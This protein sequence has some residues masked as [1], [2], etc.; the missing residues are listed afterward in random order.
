MSVEADIAWAAGIFEGEGTVYV[1][2]RKHKVRDYLTAMAA[3]DM[4]DG[5]IVNRFF[6]T[7]KM[8]TC[9]GPY[10]RYGI[11]KDGGKG[12]DRFRWTARKREEVEE[13]FLL[14]SPYLGERRTQ[15]FIDVLEA[16]S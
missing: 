16:T 4:T 12:K 6:E 15:Q 13:L 14:F 11:L 10:P 3:V 9:Y 1:H 7:I 5:D 2:V 8:G